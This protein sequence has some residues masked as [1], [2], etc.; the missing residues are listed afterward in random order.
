M[1]VSSCNLILNYKLLTKAWVVS[2][3][4]HISAFVSEKAKGGYFHSPR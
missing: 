2:C 1:L 4:Y 3:E